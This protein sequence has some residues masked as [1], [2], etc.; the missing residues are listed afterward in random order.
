[1]RQYAVIVAGGSGSRMGGGI[2]KQF[3]SLC[4]RPVLW[5]AMKAF[6][7]DNPDTSLILVLPQDFITLWNDFFSSLPLEDRYM[8]QVVNGGKTRTES[9]ANGLGLIPDDE[10]SL[11]AIHDGARPLVSPLIIRKGW[12]TA[13]ETGAAIPVVPVVDSL[14]FV[15]DDSTTLS[16]DR[17]RFVAVQTPQV[18]KSRIIKE[19]YSKV[20]EGVFTDDASVAES[21]GY[22]V[23]TFEG[24][25]DNIKIT[26]PKDL[27]IAAIIKGQF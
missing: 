25:A 19:A 1:M 4:G 5:W 9:V 22:E 17:S 2:P 13:M 8:H 7:D 3:R 16:V 21:A 18:F 20:G 10:D 14:R 11:I 6:H 15:N 27:A 26:N 23:K 12:E 24:S